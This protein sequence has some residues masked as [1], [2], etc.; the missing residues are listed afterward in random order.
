MCNRYA[1]NPLLELAAVVKAEPA[2]AAVVLTR[3]GARLERAA[4]LQGGRI[5]PLAGLP[6][7]N[8]LPAP[9]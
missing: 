2:R 3:D 4:V 7:P 6:Q 9:E 5:T 8:D 1:C